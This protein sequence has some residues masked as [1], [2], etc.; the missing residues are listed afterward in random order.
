MIH[1][2]LQEDLQPLL[3]AQELQSFHLLPTLD[4]FI[5]PVLQVPRAYHAAAAHEGRIYVVGGLNTEGRRLKSVECMDP[6]EGAS[7]VGVAVASISSPC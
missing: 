5:P 4:R 7:T 6:R 2:G 3:H 1:R